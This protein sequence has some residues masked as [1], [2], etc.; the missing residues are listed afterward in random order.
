M[1]DA[2]K[3]RTL[4][5]PLRD[6]PILP[7]SGSLPYKSNTSKPGGL[8]KQQVLLLVA[9]SALI[10][11]GAWWFFQQAKAEPLPTPPE[12]PEMTVELTSPTPPAPPTPEPPLS[13]A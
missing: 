5:G 9:V 1:N 6:D 10:H 11:G 4:P 3:H 12:I 8:S 2:V 13:A 7:V